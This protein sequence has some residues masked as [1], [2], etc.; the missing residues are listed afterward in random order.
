M[1]DA[2][3]NFLA[4]ISPGFPPDRLRQNEPMWK[5]TT[6]RVGGSADCLLFPASVQEVQRIVALTKRYALPLTVL[7][8]G[9][10]VLVRD[11]G[12]RGVVM[13]FGKPFAHI[14]HEGERLFLGAGT[15]LSVAA[16]YAADH[17]LDGLAFAAGIPGSVGGAVFMNAGAYD[18]EMKDVVSRMEAVDGAGQIVTYRGEEADFG[19]RR[20]MFQENGHILTSVELTLAR[21]DAGAIRQKMAALYARRREKQPLEYPSAGSTFKRPAGHFAGT[22][23]DETGL[24]GLSV[25]DAQVSEKHAGFIINRGHATAQD[26]LMLMEEVKRRVFLAHGVALVSEVR[27][28]GEA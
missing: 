2:Y 22:L 23:I 14:R 20:S 11:K 12:I 15:L 10:N 17:G 13:A 6:F 26:I 27:I 19:Y 21:G 24:K 16:Q 28:I 7:G 8:N 9:S 18:G 3:Q 4:E 25:G 1:T 5:H